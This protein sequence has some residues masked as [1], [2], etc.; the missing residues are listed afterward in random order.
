[1]TS[2]AEAS[3]FG[4]G[5]QS[6]FGR[7]KLVS[8]ME[9]EGRQG[10]PPE[11]A[12][13]AAVRSA[14]VGVH[15]G[16]E[17]GNIYQEHNLLGVSAPKPKG[18]AWSR[19]W[20][21]MVFKDLVGYPL[22]ETALHNELEPVFPVLQ[23]IFLH[24][25]G[26]TATGTMSIGNATKL[27]MMEMLDFAKDTDLCTP[28]FKSADLERQFYI[29]NNQEALQTTGSADRHTGGTRQ[30]F[31]RRSAATAAALPSLQIGG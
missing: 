28:T 14:Q 21:S 25:R 30:V 17:D 31:S 4:S 10:L 19:C 9:V 23:Q 13:I 15:R 18:T 7:P 1:M 24:Y 5:G 2:T 26:A 27:G 20:G 16:V 22:W 12:V 8:G 3:A 29:A 11:E 6:W